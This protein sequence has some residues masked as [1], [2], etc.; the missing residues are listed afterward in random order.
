[1]SKCKACKKPVVWALT[2]AGNLIPL[3]EFARGHYVIE[4][5]HCFCIEGTTAELQ[6]DGQRYRFH[7]CPPLRPKA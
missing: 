1:M 4:F 3:E 2:L 5:G 6:H 7:D